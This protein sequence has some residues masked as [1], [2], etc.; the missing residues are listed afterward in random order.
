MKT[1]VAE[2][3]SVASFCS[4][5]NV[6]RS[7]S[8]CN[9]QCVSLQRNCYTI[10]LP[11][12]VKVFVSLPVSLS[13]FLCVGMSCVSFCL[14]PFRSVSVSVLCLCVLCLSVCLSVCLCLCL[15]VSAASPVRSSCTL[16]PV[17]FMPSRR[18]R[19]DV[20]DEKETRSYDTEDFNEATRQEVSFC[21]YRESGR[22]RNGGRRVECE[23]EN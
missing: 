1:V 13:V 16:A 20:I 17:S 14:R 18:M 11:E 21:P 12:N 8:C 2:T 23:R 19:T 7:K 9:T 15:S 6:F 4:Q 3:V 10:V 22:G 5:P